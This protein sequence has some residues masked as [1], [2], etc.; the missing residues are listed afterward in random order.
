MAVF[1]GTWFFLSNFFPCPNGVE[2]DRV[3]YPTSEHA[4]VAAKTLSAEERDEVFRCKTAAEAKRLGKTVKLRA[5]WTPEFQLDLMLSLL[6][7]K[8]ARNPELAA[9]LDAT[10]KTELIEINEWHDRFWGVCKG[11]GQNHLG[12]LLMQVRDE[13]RR[14]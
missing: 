8:F 3:I 2:F 5:D 1:R 11:T 9:L 7:S 13:L 14:G 4:F 6:R 10:G 12:R